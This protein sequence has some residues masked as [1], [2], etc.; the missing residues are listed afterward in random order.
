MTTYAI[1][2]KSIKIK[3]TI[4]NRDAQEQVPALVDR[5]PKVGESVKSHIKEP[6]DEKG[7][8][9]FRRRRGGGGKDDKGLSKGLVVLKRTIAYCFVNISVYKFFTM[10]RDESRGFSSRWFG[11]SCGSI[12]C[13]WTLLLI[14]SVLGSKGSSHNS[15]P[16]TGLTNSDDN[17]DNFDGNYQC[18]WACSCIRQ[19]VNC[20]HRGLTQ[21]PRDWPT[22]LHAEKL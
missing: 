1:D 9:D 3:S 16:A 22:F 5:C 18:P 4:V 13:G 8:G 11:L 2:R 21:I 10:K 12:V 20:S 7:R 15:A 14:I 17:L 6:I 19:D